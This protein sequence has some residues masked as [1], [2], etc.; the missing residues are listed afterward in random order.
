MTESDVT[1]NENILIESIK[2]IIIESR[3]N[4]VRTVNTEMLSAYWNVGR[5][6]VENEQNNRDRAGYGEETLNKVSKRLRSEL[7]NGF[8]MTNLSFMRR[9]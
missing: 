8:S 3:K 5:L 2:A 9:F 4:L 1:S 7:G 6:I